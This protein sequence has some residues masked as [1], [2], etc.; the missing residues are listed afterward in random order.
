MTARNVHVASELLAVLESWTIDCN[1]EPHVT[2]RRWYLI[3]DG[4]EEA[5]GVKERRFRLLPSLRAG[6]VASMPV[7]TERDDFES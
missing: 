3:L 1:C 4:M 5:R 2:M 6:L 7:Q